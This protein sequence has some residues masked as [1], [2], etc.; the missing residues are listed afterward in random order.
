MSSFYQK[1][2]A[3]LAENQLI[4]PNSTVI[5]G[6]SGGVDSMVMLHCL[7]TLGKEAPINL[8]AAHLNH[9]IRGSSADKDE[10]LVQSYCQQNN[11]KFVVKSVNIPALAADTGASLE[12]AGHEAR[13]SFFS[14]I[15]A[16]YPG[17][18]VATAHTTDDQVETILLRI[19]KGTGVQGLQGI[20]VKRDNIIRPLLFAS[21]QEIY[22]YAHKHEIPFNEDHTNNDTSIPRN[23]IRQVLIPQIKSKVNP[24]LETSI[25]HLQSIFSDVAAINREM[26]SEAFRDCL[27]DK[28]PSE[29][30]LDISR[31]KNYFNIIKYG[32]IRESVNLLNPKAVSI[33]FSTMERLINLIK[34]SQTG[35]QIP[36]SREIR[37]LLNRRTLILRLDNFRHWSGFVVQIGKHYST[38]YFDFHCDVFDPADFHALR[39]N[40]NTEYIDLAKLPDRSLMLRPWQKGDRITPLG[41]RHSKK[42]SDIFVDQKI[43]LPMKKRI[44]LLVSGETIIWV[45]GVKLSDIFKVDSTTTKILKLTYKD[46]K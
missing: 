25:L 28:S 35:K 41:Q 17:S 26:V 1:F 40:K 29:I 2:S 7:L 13:Y 15:S 45:C 3:F 46:K 39:E 19:F 24:S 33:S 20:P 4:P 27:I 21:K 14:E 5:A 22:D 31:L 11:C 10:A 42:V 16:K 34:T 38:D 12:M 18:F 43:P 23:Y 6:V 44:P 32:V 9:Q 8:I 37:A 36:I 30:T